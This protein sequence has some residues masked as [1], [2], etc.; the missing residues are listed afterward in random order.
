M[1]STVFTLSEVAQIQ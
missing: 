1:H